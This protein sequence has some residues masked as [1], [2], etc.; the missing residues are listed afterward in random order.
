METLRPRRNTWPLHGHGHPMNWK[1]TSVILLL[2]MGIVV[3]TAAGRLQQSFSQRV[4]GG[5]DAEFGEWPWQISLIYNKYPVC[6]GSLISDKWVATAAHCVVSRNFSNFH[7]LLG[8]LNLTGTSPTQFSVAV[9]TVIVHPAYSG[10]GTRGDLALMGLA[11]AVTFNNN[12]RQVALPSQNQE[13]QSGTMCWLTGWG[14]IAEN[15]K[16]P[17]PHT[18]QKVQLPLMNYSECD[19]M[20]QK[21]FNLTFPPEY[22]TQDMICAGYPEGKKDGCQ[23]DSG[24]PLVCQSG[25]SWFLVGIVSWGDGCAQPQKPGVY[26][27]VSSFSDWM[28]G[29]IC[30]DSVSETKVSAVT[31]KKNTQVTH[32]SKMASFTL[33]KVITQGIAYIV[34]TSAKGI[35]QG[36]P[37]PATTSSKMIDQGTPSPANTSSKVMDQGSASL[38]FNL[39]R[40]TEPQAFTSSKE[41]DPDTISAGRRLQASISLTVVVVMSRILDVV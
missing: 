41:T 9:T 39:F 38:L 22:V 7:V 15:V 29:Y 18:L 31:V 19:E 24:G 27:K 32:K 13:F 10:D 17:A 23:G 11:K 21:A 2:A 30:S 12:I 3:K 8:V 25:G 20:F 35:D 14:R 34:F 5:Q 28:K 6:G 4:V 37:S 40:V 1:T 16:L 33:P 26:T 36:A